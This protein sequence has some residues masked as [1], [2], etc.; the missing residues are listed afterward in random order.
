MKEKENTFNEKIKKCDEVKSYLKTE[1]SRISY[2][3]NNLKLEKNHLSEKKSFYENKNLSFM[4]KE[5]EL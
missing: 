5:K 1:Q 2:V 3:N 4:S